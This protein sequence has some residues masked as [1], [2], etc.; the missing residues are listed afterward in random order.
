MAVAKRLTT[1]TLIL[2]AGLAAFPVQAENWPC[3]RGP[4]GDG[5]SLETNV[6]L[7]W[8]ATNNIAWKTPIPGRGHGSPIVWGDRIFLLTAIEGEQQRCVV[9]VD[10]SNGKLVW[11]RTVAQSPLEPKHKLN[12]YASS[13][14]ATDG[15]LVY[16]TFLDKDKMLV[17]AY[18]FTGRQQWLVRPGDF[19]SKH[20]FCSSPVLFKDKIIVNGDHDG[21]S[22][23]VALDRQTGKTLWK[24]D[25]E[26]KTRSYC[27]PLIREL[28][29]RTQMI[30]SGNKCVASYDPNNGKRHWI[31]DGPTEQMV[32]SMVYNEKADMLFYTGGFPQYHILG[33]K[34]NGTGNVTQTHVAWLTTKGASYVPSPVSIGDYFVIV[35][36]PGMLT[37]HQAADGNVLWSERVRGTYHASLVTAGGLV[38]VLSDL[39]V[40]TV[41]KPGPQ[42]QAVATNEL[43]EKCF[44]SPAISN[45]RLFLRGDQHL[46]SIGGH[47]AR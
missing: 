21:E 3:W 9:C 2:L 34:P 10:R 16:V 37:C 46:F 8:S 29:G 25:R 1:G 36:E 33:I 45:G 30:L 5:S 13:T 43:D 15:N 20:G 22:Y 35:N 26:N 17:A 18:D 28:D 41:V 27:T 31:I 23:I 7:H 12:N 40:M 11:L 4:R 19:F 6:P 14:P 32:A 39:G 44:A 24:I 42:F 38:Y 47:P